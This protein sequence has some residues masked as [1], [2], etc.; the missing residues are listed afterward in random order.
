M[1]GLV[2]AARSNCF[3]FSPTF[4]R[5]P[6]ILNKNNNV[7][8]T[9]INHILFPTNFP[10]FKFSPNCNTELL[11]SRVHIQQLLPHY[12]VCSW[13][14]QKSSSVAD[15]EER[16][17]RALFLQLQAVSST[18]FLFSWGELISQP[19]S[20]AGSWVWTKPPLCWEDGKESN[21]NG[22]AEAKIFLPLF[23]LQKAVRTGAC[24][25]QALS[26]NKASHKTDLAF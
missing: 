10:P 25:A 22:T 4:L 3:A 21:A 13:L 14:M 11:L 19:N 12:L 26:L 9:N 5:A 18:H 23:P 20:L 16:A 8:K 2:L 24:P 7:I 1:S 6:K 17:C 15:L